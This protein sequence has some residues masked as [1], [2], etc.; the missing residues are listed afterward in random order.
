MEKSDGLLS[1]L[2]QE[3]R[4]RV[5][6]YVRFVVRGKQARGV[7]VLLHKSMNQ[8]INMILKYR[9]EA[10]VPNDN[11]YIFGLPQTE[12]SAAFRHLIA[13]DLMRTF[14]CECGAKDPKSLRATNLKKHVATHSMTM[15]LNNDD[16]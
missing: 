10:G 6:Q 1:E 15:N 8:C 2:T 7:P 9:P 14:S 13:T 12:E 3:E 16:I 4:Q 5:T 11:P